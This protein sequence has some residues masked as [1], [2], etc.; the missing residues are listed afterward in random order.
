MYGNFAGD[1][2]RFVN[3]KERLAYEMPFIEE[4][5]SQL[6]GEANENLDILDTAAG[7]GMHAIAL[8][9]GGHRVS[10]AD[11]FPQ[12][13]EIGAENALRAKVSVT[14]K[15]AGLGDMAAAFGRGKFDL[16]LC[17]GNSLPHLVS[18]RE[19][20]EALVD[21]AA[22]L[23]PGGMVLIQNRNF[24]LVMRARQRWMEPQV[25]EQD[26]SE[27]IFQR[28]YDFLPGG[29][30]RFNIVTLKRDKDAAWQTGI[31]ST[32]LRPQFYAELSQ[33]LSDAGFHTIRAYGSMQ[34]E[35][36]QPES[37][38]NLILTARKS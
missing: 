4:Q 9:G 33:G 36:F 23:R 5:I 12:M 18:A 13:T 10:A 6:R 16:L 37:S 24:D 15:T 27:W 2:D 32:L 19:L 29:L 28:F 22:V 7:T 38:G 3:W 30:I 1:Y 26:D 21:F 25:Y 35:T 34:G 20:N 8:A 17:L 11:L 31:N 14:F